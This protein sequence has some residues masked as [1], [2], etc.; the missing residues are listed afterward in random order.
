VLHYTRLERL[1]KGKQS[2]LLDPFTSYGENEVLRTRLT[3]STTFSDEKVLLHWSLPMNQM[4]NALA[5][6]L[7]SVPKVRSHF[8]KLDHFTIVKNKVNH[9][10]TVLL[11]KKIKRIKKIIGCYR[12][13]KD[14]IPPCVF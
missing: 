11:E 13:L 14:E 3:V 7:F 2:S 10:E 1:D 8:Y 4:T 5:I 12:G 6:K 9:C